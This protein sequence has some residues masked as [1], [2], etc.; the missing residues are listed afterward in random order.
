[1]SDSIHDGMPALRLFEGFGVELEYMIVDRGDFRVRPISNRI[2]LDREGNVVDELE[3]GSLS[4][5]NELVLHVIELKTNGPV[6]ELAGLDN[7]FHRDILAINERLNPLGAR[8][9]PSAVHPFMDP[10]RETRLWPYDHSA[11][12]EAFDRIFDCRGHGWANLQSVHL[13]LSFHGEEEFV[14]LHSA[15]RLLLPL[16][17]AVA[18]ASPFLDGGETGYLDSRLE[19][20]RKNCSKV[21]SVTGHVIPEAV[22][23]VEEY[24][25]KILHRIYDDL[26]P[27]DPDGTLRYEWVNARGAI[28]RFDRST[29]EIRVVDVQECP[30]ADL[31][32]L[33]VLFHAIKRFADD[34]G[35]LRSGDLLAQDRLSS[36]LMDTIRHGEN[37]TISDEKYLTCLGFSDKSLRADEVW[38]GLIETMPELPD[39][40]R[41]VL[42]TILNNGTLAS[43]MKRIAGECSRENLLE[44]CGALC[45]CL[46]GNRM[47]LP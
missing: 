18:A 2:L 13:N 43:R 37:T 19:V 35:I 5:S 10:Y 11:V 40:G 32:L 34:P 24:R 36:V 33:T 29:I 20:Y 3:Q 31:A 47:L 21:F 8:L 22:G 39:S 15:I 28:A 25:K 46:E 7:I 30:M 17:P 6:R 16:I 38:R 14:R 42:E 27:Y 9:M 45:D 44:L 26:S 4:W 1:M 23:S 12:Y 41:R